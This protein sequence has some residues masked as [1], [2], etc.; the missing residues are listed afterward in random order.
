MVHK[1]IKKQA[2]VKMLKEI[3]NPFCTV[4]LTDKSGSWF[5]P[6]KCVNKPVEQ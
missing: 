3:F 6:S 4:S 5:L 1:I 2:V